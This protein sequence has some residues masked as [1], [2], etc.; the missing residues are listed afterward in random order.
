MKPSDFD[1]S[2][3]A[4]AADSP[5]TTGIAE[6]DTN[7]TGAN[8]KR[9]RRLL[10][11]AAVVLVTLAGYATWWFLHAR[12]FESTDDAYVASD[13]VQIT[14]EV[15][16]AVT[17]VH[18]D[19]TQYVERGQLL[20]ELDRADAHVAMAQAEAA[21]AA[22]VRHVRSLYSEAAG[23][24]AQIHERELLLSA[25]RADLDRR[26]QAAGD[27]AVSAE[28]LQHA[29]DE[30]AQRQAALGATRESLRSVLAQ[31]DDTTL[32]T[33][34]QVLAA[35]ARVREAGLA[36]KRTRIVAP[37]SGTVARRG[38]QI[39]ARIAPGAPLMAV[40]PLSHAWVDANFK[41]VQL[42]HMRIGQPVELRADLYGGD[43]V[44]HGRI[45]GLGAGSGSAFALLP[46]QNASGNWIKIVQRVPVRIALD[47]EE[48]SKYPL[49]VGLSMHARVD[50]HDVSGPLAATEV[51]GDPQRLVAEGEEQDY[52]AERIARIIARNGGAAAPGSAAP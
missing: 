40:V 5:A 45:A 26:E 44:Y 39:G 17:A 32:E 37:V 33:H 16:G 1:S 42:T 28:E 24:R 31:I 25:A 2:T 30:V 8:G 12:Y 51:R 34:P 7:V 47:P 52:A 46:A 6:H 38:V 43:V 22:S 21:L 13:V 19:D 41:E 27:G 48:L 10:M 50:L 20:V 35:A 4:A 18:V 29:R 23:L 15:A 9:R 36:L 3:R 11:L 14:S 49:R